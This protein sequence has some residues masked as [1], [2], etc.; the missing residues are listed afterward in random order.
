M[1]T[2]NN[3]LLNSLLL[4]ALFIPSTAY[5]MKRK[6]ESFDVPSQKRQRIEHVRRGYTVA[7]VHLR[8]ETQRE[9][10]LFE[11]PWEEAILSMTIKNMLEDLGGVNPQ[12]GIPLHNVSVESLK[13]VFA[14]LSIIAKKE[15]DEKI[16]ENLKSYINFLSIEGLSEL[17]LDANYLDI[18]LL[19][20]A[21]KIVAAE[22]YSSKDGLTILN[23]KK[24][25]LLHDISHA[26]VEYWPNLAKI[27]EWLL[28]ANE[29]TS[30]Y[31]PREPYTVGFVSGGKIL[32]AGSLSP[33]IIW[34]KSKSRWEG[35]AK[36]LSD[37]FSPESQCFSRDGKFA[38][39]C[40][41]DLHIWS[42][43]KGMHIITVTALASPAVASCFSPD[44][45]TLTLGSRD[46][47]ITF[48]KEIDGRL[49]CTATI[50]TSQSEILSLSY[51]RD[52]KRLTSSSSRN[53]RLYD[54]VNG[55][56]K[57]VDIID[58]TDDIYSALISPDDKTIAINFSG[59]IGL[60]Y[61]LEEKWQIDVLPGF[62]ACFSPD[63]KAIALLSH[64]TPQCSVQVWNEVDNIWTCVAELQGPASNLNFSPDGETLAVVY[65]NQIR[66]WNIPRHKKTIQFLDQF[67]TLEQMTLINL[68]YEAYFGGKRVSI[69]GNLLELFNSLPAEVRAT[70][71]QKALDVIPR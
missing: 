60:M 42:G 68:I 32:A 62:R 10:V 27:R 7:V 69:E 23:M 20:E 56:W 54:E 59:F 51:S 66:L 8:I 46:K 45:K 48:W 57:C 13:H 61:H 70:L 15:T 37:G 18:A 33:I 49:T 16:L 25:W 53:V 41:N 34:S 47:T 50:C 40:G 21:A 38:Y 63:G 64:N 29:D 2:V 3:I 71:E 24:S 35:L 65:G 55:S 19:F 44:G 12:G 28:D 26:C 5:S 36:L 39:C 1:I 11:L 67:I 43:Y 17:L 22:R 30:A 52:G 58:F 31:L 4:S 9:I 6:F 14:C